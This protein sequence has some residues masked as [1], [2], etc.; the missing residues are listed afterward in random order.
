MRHNF[1]LNHQDGQHTGPW[2]GPGCQRP[3]TLSGPM[4]KR[5]A[6]RA[7]THRVAQGLAGTLEEYWEGPCRRCGQDI[8]VHVGYFQHGCGEVYVTDATL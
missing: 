6:R 8:M 1:Y 5:V 7:L 2:V 3:D 4:S